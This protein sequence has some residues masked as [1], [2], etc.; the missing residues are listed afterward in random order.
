MPSSFYFID[1]SDWLDLGIKL[2]SELLSFLIFTS[3]FCINV[4]KDPGYLSQYQ[5]YATGWT[6]EESFNYQLKQEFFSRPR[7]PEQLWIP[8]ASYALC[9]KGSVPKSK[10]ARDWSWHRLPS[11]VE[12]KN[13]WVYISTLQHV[14]TVQCLIN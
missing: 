10:A 7:H 5:D 8:P 9:T 4:P 14:F 1:N 12:V 3:F 11:N 2:L 13:M 6:T